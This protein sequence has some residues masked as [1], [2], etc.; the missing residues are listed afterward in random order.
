M[1][2]RVVATSRG[3]RIARDRF[4]STDMKPIFAAAILT[5]LLP[6]PCTHAQQPPEP[7]PMPPTPAASQSAP[8]PLPLQSLHGLLA[9]QVFAREPLTADRA[10]QDPAGSA[11]WL[12]VAV[13]ADALVAS[14]GEL[15]SLIVTARDAGATNDATRRVLPIADVKFEAKPGKWC[16]L[17]RELAIASLAEFRDDPSA[18]AAQKQWL[19]S[20]LVV[21]STMKPASPVTPPP[22]P[23]ANAPPANAPRAAEPVPEPVVWWVDVTAPI[24]IELAVL[25]FG[26]QAVPVPWPLLRVTTDGGDTTIACSADSERLTKAPVST[27]LTERPSEEL[28]R[29]MREHFGTAPAESPPPRRRDGVSPR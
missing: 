21:A 8:A 12:A 25:P 10:P 16:L 1:V 6:F 7:T 28:R 15:S 2:R 27:T 3:T 18:N 13:I 22:P 23:P 19:A 9:E 11:A 26:K 24:R 29:R 5:V 4:W 14:N 17:R 20:R